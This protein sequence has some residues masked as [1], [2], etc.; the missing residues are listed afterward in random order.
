[1]RADSAVVLARSSPARPKAFFAGDSAQGD[2]VACKKAGLF[3]FV[4][5]SR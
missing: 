1:M 4:A 3:W 5:T 2:G